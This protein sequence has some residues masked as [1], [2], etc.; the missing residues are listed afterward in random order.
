MQTRLRRVEEFIGENNKV[1]F[2]V[3]FKGRE[4]AH[5]D[6]GFDLLKRVMEI[7]GEKVGIEREAKLE[8]RSITLLI[9]R[10]RGNNPINQ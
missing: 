5:V 4:M 7:L 6:I 3:K 8:G 1:M 2:R 9:G 10:S